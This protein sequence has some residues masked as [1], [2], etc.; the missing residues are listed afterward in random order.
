[1]HQTKSPTRERFILLPV[2][3]IFIFAGALT[4]LAATETD[5][6][7]P[8]LQIK[9][10]QTTGKI[11][12]AFYGLM[13]E[14]INYSY[15][16]GL[17]GELIRNRTFKADALPAPITP[18]NYDPAKYYPAKFAAHVTPKFWS[19]INGSMVLDTNTPLN[20]ALNVSLKLDA[21]KASKSRPVGIANDGYWGIPVHP[22]TTYRVSFYAKAKNFNGPLTVSL[23]HP[24]GTNQG[25]ISVHPLNDSKNT[26]SYDWY[27]YCPVKF[28]LTGVSPL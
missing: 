8:T 9:A 11:S 16:G 14:E 12:P 13:T 24:T 20:E 3:L 28:L 21:S 19:V 25:T 10:D 1:M 17:Y 5:A 4:M 22:N 18:E 26:K 2:A 27:H 15:E 7:T 23:I 6:S